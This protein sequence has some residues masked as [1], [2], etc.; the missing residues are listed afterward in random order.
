MSSNNRVLYVDRE[1]TADPF[2]TAAVEAAG[3][4]MERAKTIEEASALYEKCDIDLLLIQA[5]KGFLDPREVIDCLKGRRL[6]MPTPVIIL[7][8]R[9]EEE[10][11]CI[12]VHVWQLSHRSRMI[13]SMNWD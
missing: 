8:D 10:E 9:E 1:E 3:A 12:R 7:I 5:R 4:H 11:I 2:V 6:E 13:L